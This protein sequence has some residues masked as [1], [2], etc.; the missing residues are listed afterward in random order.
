MEQKIEI[1]KPRRQDEIAAGRR[2][3]RQGGAGTAVQGRQT[4][5]LALGAKREKKGRDDGQRD[6]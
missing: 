1:E 2:R 5:V 3:D 6:G 4:L